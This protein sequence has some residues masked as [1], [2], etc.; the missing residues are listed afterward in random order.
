[1]P[2]SKR[3]GGQVARYPGTVTTFDLR[4]VRLRSGEQFRDVRDVQLEPLH[5]GGERYLPVPEK[6]EAAL[7]I[8]PVSSGLLFELD[9][10]VRLLGP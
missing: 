5:L 10:E 9:L 2:F 4:T 1:M 6:P 7:T 3:A 8:S